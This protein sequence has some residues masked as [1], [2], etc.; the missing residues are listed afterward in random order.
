MKVKYRTIPKLSPYVKSTYGTFKEKD[1]FIIKKLK[2]N[3]KNYKKKEFNLIDVGCGNA[4]LLYRIKKNFPF[5]KL[6]GVDRERKFLDVAKKFRG[7]N[8]VEFEVN[9]IYKIKK[10]Y[11]VVLCSSTFQIFENFRKPLK[12][13]L[14]LTKK[15]G[16]IMI[17]GLFNSYD[18][19][20]RLIYC[21]N[22]NNISKNLW[23]KDWNQHSI[24][25]V[26]E[27]LKENNIRSFKF[28]NL[29]MDKNIKH[30]NK[31]H[32]NQFTFRDRSNRNIITNGTNMILNRKLLVIKL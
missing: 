4:T 22:S 2:E 5:F 27:F 1:K 23:R 29:T 7:L 25:V 10:K 20:T 3:I 18:V 13:L 19:E 21:D 12:K 16:L 8:D 28:F 31:I 15:N 14:S 24:K 17:D 6:K 30:N 26:S 32:V 11:D 9:D